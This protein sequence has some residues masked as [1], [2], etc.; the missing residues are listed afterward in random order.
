M[1]KGYMRGFE[2]P[3]FLHSWV[4]ERSPADYRTYPITMTFDEDETAIL[5]GVLLNINA[6]VHPGDV[7]ALV[8]YEPDDIR[9]LWKKVRTYRD[10]DE[11]R[12]ISGTE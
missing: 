9:T 4:E 2:I 3:V 1:N 7:R 11:M 12:Y 10:A 8:G 5:L 6:L